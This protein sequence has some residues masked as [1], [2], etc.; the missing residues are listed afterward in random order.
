MWIQINKYVHFVK[1]KKNECV[2]CLDDRLEY[3]FYLPDRHMLGG[4]YNYIIKYDDIKKLTYSPI[5]NKILIQGTHTFHRANYRWEADPLTTTKAPE[6][7]FA[8][9]LYVISSEDLEKTLVE[10]T[11]L[12]FDLDLANDLS[13]KYYD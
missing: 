2:S 4:W 11:N 10:K 1:P 13:W 12:K 7:D 3:Q 5:A 9:P 6:Q 8:I